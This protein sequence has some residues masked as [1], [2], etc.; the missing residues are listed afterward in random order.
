VRSVAVL[1]DGNG[2]RRDFVSRRSGNLSGMAGNSVEM[3]SAEFAP[4][5]AAGTQARAFL[6]A[7]LETWELDGLGEVTELLTDELVTNAVRHA[8]SEMTVRAKRRPSRIRVEVAD[9]SQDR[10]VVMHPRPSELHG[11]GML[12]VDAL[13]DDWGAELHD[14]GK[15]VWFEIDARRASD[16]MH[17][18]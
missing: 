10:P 4:I 17:G 18:D 13:A 14:H 6:R 11:R 2:A 8:G 5:P 12:L 16:E 9:A 7:A 3:V 15:T 1:P